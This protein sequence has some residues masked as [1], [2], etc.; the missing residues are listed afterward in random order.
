MGTYL[1]SGKD[2]S[3]KGE[4]WASPLNFVPEMQWASKPP[5]PLWPLEHGISLPILP[6]AFTLIILLCGLNLRNTD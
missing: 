5:L 1:E 4:G 3:A 2:E 6:V